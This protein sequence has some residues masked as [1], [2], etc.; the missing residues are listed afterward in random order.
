MHMHI[1]RRAC[2]TEGRA[3]S[4]EGPAPCTAPAAAPH[5]HACLTPPLP[6]SLPPGELDAVLKLGVPRSKIIFA[7]PCKRAL[8]M[9]Y[10]QTQNIQYTTFDTPSELHKIAGGCPGI[11][12]VLRL[13][14]DDPDAKVPLGL[15]YGAQPEEARM[16]LETAISL[17]L[18]VGRWV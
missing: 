9:K 4:L 16:L 18:K 11:G 13:R 7:H 6:C 3:S 1:Q 12:C 14:C 2:S 5:T 8:D 17:G 10:A 15:K